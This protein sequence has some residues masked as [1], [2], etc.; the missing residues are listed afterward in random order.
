MVG[1]VG[2]SNGRACA[3]RA[4]IR[5]PQKA[6]RRKLLGMAVWR[7]QFVILL[8]V[9]SVLCMSGETSAAYQELQGQDFGSILSSSDILKHQRALKQDIAECMYINATINSQ[10]FAACPKSAGS[11]TYCYADGPKGACV[12]T[13]DPV[14]H[15][16]ASPPCKYLLPLPPD[17]INGVC[18]IIITGGK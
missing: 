6:S 9:P 8:I 11:Y 17:A 14:T 16:I 3:Q 5:S 4:I 12:P 13:D 2:Q 18:G 10:A 7:Y 15:N 1:P